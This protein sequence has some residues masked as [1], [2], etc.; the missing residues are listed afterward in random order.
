MMRR[1]IA[2]VCDEGGCP[3]CGGKLKRVEAGH[4]ECRECAAIVDY[5][6][7]GWRYRLEPTLRELPGILGA[8]WSRTA[9]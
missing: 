1:L 7:A 6:K 8:I 3:G 5:R 9:A 2:I 4:H